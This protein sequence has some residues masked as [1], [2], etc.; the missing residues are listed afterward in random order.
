MGCM[1]AYAWQQ[2]RSVD[3][4]IHPDDMMVVVLEAFPKFRAML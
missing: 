3:I 2:E 1:Y 4:C